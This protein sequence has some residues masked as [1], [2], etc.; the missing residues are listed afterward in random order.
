MIAPPTTEQLDKAMAGQLDP[1][2]AIDVL[3]AVEGNLDQAC[4]LLGPNPYTPL[5]KS[6]LVRALAEDP[7][8]LQRALRVFSMIEAHD[9]RRKVKLI[10]EA[11]VND[12][13]ADEAIKAYV[14]I[15][16]QI[17]E[18]TKPTPQQS[19]GNTFQFIFD[20]LPREAATAVKGLSKLNASEREELRRIAQAKS[21][22]PA[23]SQ[24]DGPTME[25][26]LLTSGEATNGA[27]CASTG[28]RW[29]S[30]EQQPASD[31]AA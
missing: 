29:A 16:D 26:H 19:G 21:V 3:L 28:T 30:G 20:N 31:Q 10:A 8:A 6:E 7:T 4:E 13:E 11:G 17:Q 25:G 1:R 12:L 15:T 9:L 24:A 27:S 14:D 18:M 5:P 22:G 2:K 23:S